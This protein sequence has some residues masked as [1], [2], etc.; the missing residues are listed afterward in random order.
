MNSMSDDIPASSCLSGFGKV[1]NDDG[2]RT[3]CYNLPDMVLS[4][5]MI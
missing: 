5:M 4:N 2:Q 1:T 3:I